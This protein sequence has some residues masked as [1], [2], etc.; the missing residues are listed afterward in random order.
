[1]PVICTVVVVVPFEN[2]TVPVGAVAVEFAFALA[3][4]AVYVTDCP[5]V[6]AEGF[7][8]SVVVVFAFVIVSCAGAICRFVQL[9]VAPVHVA[10]TL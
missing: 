2:V 7:D 4:V 9:K 3:T 1:L 8:A 6:G 10:C 5:A